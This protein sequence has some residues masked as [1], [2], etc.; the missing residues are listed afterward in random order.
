MKK[1]SGKRSAASLDEQFT[2]L[3]KATFET[4]AHQVLYTRRIYPSSSFAPTTVWGVRCHA[5]RAKDVV[6]YIRDSVETGLS[7]VLNGSATSLSLLIVDD[8]DEIHCDCAQEDDQGMGSG[9]G[10]TGDCA[11]V[12]KERLTLSF[13]RMGQVKDLEGLEQTER[14]MRDLILRTLSLP[15]RKGQA[16]ITDSTSF[17]LVWHLEPNRSDYGEMPRRFDNGTWIEHKRAL[18]GGLVRRPIYQA[19][20]ALVQ[21]NFFSQI[22][23][24]V[25]PRLKQQT[26]VAA[27]F[28]KRYEDDDA[29]EI[30]L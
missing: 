17:R 18:E 25:K 11:L 30:V 5:C 15:D 21:M 10:E 2:G 19:S 13:V 16:I 28:A 27:T 9:V 4:W 26:S 29:D 8:K 6:L 12:E 7:A 1:S 23:A 14:S 22:K 3:L 24:P 20:S